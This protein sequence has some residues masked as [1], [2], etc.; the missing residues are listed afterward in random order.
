MNCPGWYV[1]FV[2]VRASGPDGGGFE[3]V[4]VDMVLA[5]QFPKCSSIFV[6]RLCGLGDVTAVGKQEIF[7]VRALEPGLGF[8]EGGWARSH[9]G[10]R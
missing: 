2:L 6:C 7:S 1:D 8:A 5:E 4:D 10:M 9:F 3:A